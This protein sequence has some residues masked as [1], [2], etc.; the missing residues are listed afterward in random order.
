MCVQP[1]DLLPLISSGLNAVYAMLSSQA[2]ESAVWLLFI[3]AKLRSLMLPC[4]PV[5]YH[6]YQIWAATQT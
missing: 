1:E 2:G 5:V 3:V 6:L 4:L